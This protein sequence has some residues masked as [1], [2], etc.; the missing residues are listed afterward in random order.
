MSQSRRSEL[1]VR[2]LPHTDVEEHPGHQYQWRVTGSRPS[3]RIAVDNLAATEG[4]FRLRMPFVSDDPRRTA[5]VL[6]NLHPIGGTSR[7][8]QVGGGGVID[9]V[10]H[11]LA[12]T[13]DLFVDIPLTANG[14]DLET[15]TIVPVRQV[16]AAARMAAKIVGSLRNEP[17][18]RSTLL[19][20]TLNAA[21]RGGRGALRE[22]LVADY[23]GLQRRQAGPLTISY[24]SWVK[25]H[26]TL[27]DADRDAVMA[28]VEQL[29]AHA[30]PPLISIVVPTYNTSEKWLRAAIESVVEQW[31]P[32]WE[33]C[34]ADD[35]STDPT[36]ARILHEYAATDRRIKVTVRATNGHISAA[37]NSAL[38][39]ATGAFVALLDHDDELRPHALYLVADAIATN[40]SLDIVYSDEDKLT[41]RGA[42]VDQHFK[43]G[44][45]YDLLLG[46]NY[47]S[48]L[49]VLRT[50]VVREA[51][52]FRLG[53]EGSQDYD[54]F[55]R[56]VERTDPSNI[57]HL[58]FVLYHWRAIAGSTAAS[59]DAK[60]YTEDA[61]QRAIAEHLERMGTP[62]V[63]E[64]G[65][66]PTTYR[67]RWPLPSSPPLVS[68]VIP[69][70]NGLELV[71]QCIDSIETTTTYRTY[72]IVLVDNQSDDQAA[73]RY[74]ASLE[75]EG[76]IRLVHFDAPFNYSAINNAGVEA[77]SGEI[78]CLLN[79][80]IEVISADWLDE[81]VS[82]LLRPGVGAVGAKLLYPDETIQHAG[83]V[84]G[85]GGV[86]GHGHK[87]FHRNDFGYFSRL[88]LV[89]EVGA[90]TAACLVLKRST[91]DGVGGLDA[92]HLG[93]AFN[94]IDL[95][96]RIRNAGERVLFT[97][98][99]EL[100]HHESISRGGEDTAEKQA[101]FKA[102]ITYMLDTWADE[103]LK[104]PAYSPNLSLEVESF[105]PARVPR[106][107]YAWRPGGGS[108][109]P[110][111]LPTIPGIDR[112]EEPTTTLDND[113]A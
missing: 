26:D 53:F 9:K 113:P 93:V 4:W 35:A 106:V 94:D 36:V 83:V 49:T 23:E 7:A 47:L 24:E 80:D 67:Q 39:L 73:L 51:G 65:P 110:G 33:L 16:E 41:S 104:D 13:T 85:L 61:A 43:P 99:A 64:V 52:G 74:F 19:E 103:L 27:D 15:P 3:F 71:R 38:E 37:S 6:R 1:V 91:W 28:A 60:D 59:T 46:Q 45:N 68:I 34:L 100:Y 102:E 25:W 112:S 97:P 70:R 12:G 89:H 54:L 108:L 50:S 109:R 77:C 32:H 63:V 20:R 57:H 69:T 87:R 82:Q 18:A 111:S 86:A 101:R 98:F 88:K 56:C 75:S 21:R 55:L 79:N 30:S 72:E 92:E 58:P 31:Y 105:A 29:N 66:A 90:V 76:R 81:M 96:L 17:A 78:I 42:R 84:L 14:F 10:L 8:L 44:F 95:C 40:P 2:L 22:Q 107:S 5:P 48:H 11:V 62:A